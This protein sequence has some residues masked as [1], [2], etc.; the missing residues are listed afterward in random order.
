MKEWMLIF[1]LVILILNGCA[2]HE[3]VLD[4]KNQQAQPVVSNQAHE[5]LG[6]KNS[7]VLFIIAQANFRDEELAVPEQILKN[8]GYDFDVAS[9]TTNNAVGMLGAVV[10]P[11]VTVKDVNAN[12]YELIVVVGGSGAPALADNPDVLNLLAQAENSSKKIA[13]I[14]LGPMAL[15]RAGVLEGRKATVFNTS[16][17]IAALQAGGAILVNNNVVIEDKLVTANGPAAV[18]EFGNALVNL[19]KS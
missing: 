6:Q 13:G 17:A 2:I 19:L 11:D 7:K 9:I 15:A 3:S 1:I 5:I 8:A 12:D 4:E 14:C 16:E 18:E 10:K